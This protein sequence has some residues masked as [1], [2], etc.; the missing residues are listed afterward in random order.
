VIDEIPGFGTVKLTDTDATLP[1]GLTY[2]AWV[3]P[4]KSASSEGAYYIEDDD[5]LH[6]ALER[7]YQQIGRMRGR[8]HETLAQVDLPPAIAAM[9][10]ATCL[11]E[12]A[13]TGQQA[14]VEGFSSG[15]EVEVYG[16]VDSITYPH[17]PSF[18]RYEYPSRLPEHVRDY[19]ADVSRRVITAIGLTNSA[20][21]IE[22]FWDDAK[23][24][25]TLL[26]INARHSQ[27]HARLFHLVDGAPN[28][29]CMLDIALGRR[30]TL[31]RR[32]G[33]YSVAALWMLRCFT[34]GIPRRVP[35]SAEIAEL[36][37][38]IPGTT[39]EVVARQGRRLSEGY[40]GDSYSYVLARIVV[41]GHTRA[42]VEETYHRCAEALPFEIEDT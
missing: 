1:A 15:G 29:V 11:V 8:F 21:N 26:E 9:G 13:A 34:D 25:L 5:E 24:R 38:R 37:A 33:D 12:E 3:K 27:S 4:I 30:P 18:L 14:T 10:P 31:P 17:V 39:V 40:R 20:F 32:E 23:Q 22:F 41:A 36:E 19:M 2:P 28:H 7:E 35:S 42:E 16:V 6:A